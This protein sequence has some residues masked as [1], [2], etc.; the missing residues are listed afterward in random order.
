MTQRDRASIHVGPGS[1]QPKI[2]LDGQVLRCESLIHLDQIDVIETETSFLKNTAGRW[3]RPDSHNFRFHSRIRPANN[4]SDRRKI[5]VSNKF[6]ISDYESSGA[7]HD[8]GRVTCGDKT[9]L[10]KRWFE[11]GK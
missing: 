7:I 4:P 6:F 5:V 11:F 8:S 10:R 3:H 2:L 1:I 9:I